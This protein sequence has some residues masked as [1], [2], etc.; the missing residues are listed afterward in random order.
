MDGSYTDI[1]HRLTL[2]RSHFPGP[3]LAMVVDSILAG[4]TAGELWN[5]AEVEH[6]PL[7]V[8]WDRG[9]EILYLAGDGQAAPAYGTFARFMAG[10]LARAFAEGVQRLKVRTLSHSL[11]GGVPDLF[12]GI[13]LSQT[14]THFSVYDSTQAPFIPSPAASG[15]TLLPITPELLSSHDLTGVEYIREEIGGMWPSM[16]RFAERG[17]GV[18]AVVND[19]VVC[20]CTAEYVGPTF[21]GIG[22]ATHPQYRRQGIATAATAHFIHEALA[23]GLVACWEC[24]RANVASMRVAA[25]AGFVHQTEEVYWIGFLT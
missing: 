16:E 19:A 18:V 20:W 7:L 2:Y 9:N 23:R 8:L 21:C 4:N 12:A 25:K 22:I 5:L 1:A 3:H 11:E 14:V 24:D 15:V 10:L 17:F 6:P 13:E